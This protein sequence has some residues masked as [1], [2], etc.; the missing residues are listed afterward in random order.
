MKNREF[1]NIADGSH[2]K[3]RDY[4]VKFV[5]NSNYLPL[6]GNKFIKKITLFFYFKIIRKIHL[7]ILLIINSKL[8]FREPKNKKNIIF[9]GCMHHF[10][11]HIVK[12]KSC[13]VLETRIEHFN[14]IYITKKIIYYLIKNFYKNSLKMNYLFILIKIIKPKN[15]ITLIDN[16]FDFF[17]IA[18]LLKDENINFYALQNA[19]RRNETSYVEKK[20]YI[21]NYFVFS[22]YEKNLFKR[23]HNVK[24]FIPNGSIKAELAKKYF[25]KKKVKKNLF[26]I[27]LISEPD[28]NLQTDD[29]FTQAKDIDINLALVA[30]YC[31]RFSKKFKKKIIIMGKSDITHIDGKKYETEFYRNFISDRKFKIFFH[32]KKKFGAYKIILQSK[33]VIGCTSSLLRESFAFKK[34]VLC[35]KYV[36][37][38]N[39]ILF[40][41]EGICSLKNKSYI[42]FE[43]RLNKILKMT[44][45]SYVKRIKNI[46][47]LYFCKKNALKVLNNTL[48]NK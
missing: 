19:T 44:Y 36:K 45:S 22:K 41:S 32:D 31:L 6:S 11:K 14:K 21:P 18:Q 2:L 17:L 20:R 3:F 8:I 35:C 9:D 24:G 1:L 48:N 38:K 40:P 43:N 26:D 37:D 12:D 5:K 15:V 34:K 46:D 47:N 4:L 16:S 42:E 30:D 29:E 13:H 25:L 10:T 28:I 27:C 23:S 7:M 39:G 33:V